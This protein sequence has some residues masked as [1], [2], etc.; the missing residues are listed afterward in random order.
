MLTLS[1]LGAA[2]LVIGTAHTAKLVATDGLHRVAPI[3]RF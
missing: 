1:I 2:A 3:Q